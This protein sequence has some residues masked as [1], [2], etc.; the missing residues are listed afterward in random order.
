MKKVLAVLL[1]GA[2]LTGCAIP[3]DMKQDQKAEKSALVNYHK[4][5][6]KAYRTNELFEASKK[7]LK[8]TTAAKTLADLDVIKTKKELDAILGDK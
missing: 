5:E 6:K 7:A 4:A 8:V 3:Q 1:A 2:M